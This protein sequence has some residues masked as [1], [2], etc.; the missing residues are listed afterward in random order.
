MLI[1]NIELVPKYEWD[2]I[3]SYLALIRLLFTVFGNFIMEITAWFC[4]S[5]FIRMIKMLLFF[6]TY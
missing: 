5:F 4:L 6:A 2:T 3:K 1:Q